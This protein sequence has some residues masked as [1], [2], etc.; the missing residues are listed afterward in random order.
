MKAYT[1]FL[2]LAICVLFSN[3]IN[4]QWADPGILTT[5]SNPQIRNY[6]PYLVLISTATGERVIQF[7]KNNTSNSGWIYQDGTDRLRLSASDQ[8]NSNHLNI[9]SS[10]N[11]GIGVQD[12][13]TKLEVQFT[14]KNGI[15]I[16][17]NNTGDA[18]LQIENGGGGH[19]I[20]D[21]D[22]DGHSL[23][24]E[25]AGELNF[26]TGGATERM[27][28]SNTGQLT[29][30]KTSEALRLSG[31]GSYM[32]F[33][34]GSTFN[35]YVSHNNTHMTLWN[36]QA[37]GNLYFG[38]GNG[39][40]MTIHASGMVGIGTSAPLAKLDVAGDANIRGTNVEC[41]SD[42]GTGI[43]NITIGAGRTADGQASFQLVSDQS[44]YSD[45]GVKFARFGNGFSR[46]THRGTNAFQFMSEGAANIGFLT[47]STL[48]MTVEH[49]TGDV[50]IGTSNPAS[51]LHVAGDIFATGTITSSD[52]RLKRDIDAYRAGLDEVMKLRPV[53]YF[54]NGEAGIRTE[55]KH[56]GLI[57]QELEAVQPDL[58]GEYLYQDKDM[59]DNVIE[60]GT[61][62]YIQ[63][64]AIKYMLVNA[65]QEQQEQIAETESTALDLQSEIELLKAEN[66][67]IRTENMEMKV[68][69]KEI[70]QV[71][72]D[73]KNHSAHL[74]V[75]NASTTAIDLS[76]DESEAKLWQNQP[77][78]FRSETI[79]RYF[80]PEDASG[81][82]LNIF[83][84]DG[85]LLKSLRISEPGF[86]QLSIKA[87]SLPTG[88]Y[89]YQFKTDEGTL[90]SKTMILK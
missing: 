19:F 89:L 68:L 51:R 6:S 57:A 32:T 64:G 47:N 55:I 72:I 10:G 66:E 86:G 4:A 67:V 42:A 20:F 69:L 81:A 43:A 37:T 53:S 63:E 36:K 7:K 12:P 22:S 82:Q 27:S 71:V 38:A 11:V 75:Q 40:R 21:D 83:R 50:G 41:G 15:L 24:I 9:L 62:K 52:R 17:G 18:F 74:S 60:E 48:R 23:D 73:L 77:N 46:F 80:L 59:W 3:L 16:D 78:P 29:I 34:N 65:I 61:Y 54:Y 87:I 35:G 49:T 79:I 58:V 30:Y 45:W 90:I 76:G 31:S 88:N 25:S 13:V 28:L 85:K 26:N 56:V 44:S 8:P 2:L 84:S 5:T 70:Q 1:A 39:T 33:Y 14:G